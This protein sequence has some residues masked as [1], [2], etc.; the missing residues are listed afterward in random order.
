MKGP[1][2]LSRPSLPHSLPPCL[3]SP[4]PPPSS[5][6]PPPAVLLSPPKSEEKSAFGWSGKPSTAWWVRGWVVLIYV[7]RKDVF[8]VPRPLAQSIT[9]T[10]SAWVLSVDTL[11]SLQANHLKTTFSEFPQNSHTRGACLPPSSSPIPSFL[12]LTPGRSGAAAWALL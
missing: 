4:P 2:L 11:F 7:G 9:A 5:P 10:F 3:L 8:T 1:V 12:L 6:P